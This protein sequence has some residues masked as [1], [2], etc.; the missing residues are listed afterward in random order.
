M[1][2]EIKNLAKVWIVVITCLSY[3][4]LITSRIPKGILRLISLLPIFYLFITLPS[5]LSAVNLTGFTSFFL[6][7]LANF[8][9]L[10]FAFG[11]GPLSQPNKLF[12]FILAASLPIKIKPN[13]TPKSKNDIN[14]S[15]QISNPFE[16]S[17]QVSNFIKIVI[18]IVLVVMLLL[19]YGYRQY[20]H[21]KAILVLD[22]YRVFL[23]LEIGLAMCTSL[24]HI[25][26]F[27]VEPQ[28]NKPH[29][30][31]SLQNFWG[32]RWNLMVTNILRLTVYNPVRRIFG[33]I[34]REKWT[35]YPGVIITFI[36]SGF[37]H[38]MVF[39]HLLRVHPTWEA[40]WFFVLQG[41]SVTVE[42]FIKK[43]LATQWQLPSVVSR[44]LVVV[45]LLATVIWLFFPPLVRNNVF[46]KSYEEYLIIVNYIK[47]V[48]R[49]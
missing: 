34:I 30:A 44:P 2:G 27:E 8:K 33:R 43:N 13:P 28:F 1:E 21:H 29:L 4:Y 11:Q 37:M 41:V 48:L 47:R 5:S 31:T 16:K 3:C 39:Y 9:L 26:G 6:A 35:Q 25:F 20:I 14:P 36:V 19:V 42:I 15:P 24:A 18:K 12:H 40:T 45:F 7:W 23:S 49:M 22:F 32:R 17:H 38:E 10:L 46:Y